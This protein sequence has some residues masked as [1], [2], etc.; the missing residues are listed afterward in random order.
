M[1]LSSFFPFA[2]DTHLVVVA[3]LVSNTEAFLDELERAASDVALII[4]KKSSIDPVTAQRVGGTFGDRLLEV[5]SPKAWAADSG[6]VVTELNRVAPDGQIVLID[7]GGY[8]ASSLGAIVEALPGRI[9]GVVEG[10]ENGLR[11]YLDRVMDSPVPIWS[12][13]GSPLKYPENHLVGVSVVHSIESVLRDHDQVLQA[14]RAC[15]IG[16]GRVGRSAA[17]ALRGRGVTTIVFDKSEIAMAEAASRGFRVMRRLDEALSRSNLVVC[18]TGRRALDGH[19][20]P[21]LTD[22]T[23]VATVTSADDELALEDLGDGS[24]WARRSF[25]LR[26]G[27]GVVEEFYDGRQKSF[28]LIDGGNAVNFL[29]GAVIGPAIR[30]IEGEKLAA[31]AAISAGDGELGLGNELT[32]D[33]RAKIASLWLDHFLEDG[34][35]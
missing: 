19:T 17:E 13:A 23:F 5:E 34:L 15:V 2:P 11:R 7:L 32:K 29:H 28:Y 9:A 27:R 30:L 18:A 26:S 33:E 25:D 21:H 6:L 3:H 35:V 1:R 22:G 10:T 4:P 16:F 24:G 12:V 8:F 14:S 31:A 20:F